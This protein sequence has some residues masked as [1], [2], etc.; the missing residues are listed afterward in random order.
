MP[1]SIIK[2]FAKE[3]G[4]SV[5]EVEKLWNQAKESAKKEGKKESDDSFYAYVTGTLKKML[6]ISEGTTTMNETES[7]SLKMF[8]TFLQEIAAADTLKTTPIG[9]DNKSQSSI[10]GDTKKTM[11][12]IAK[13]ANAATGA[14]DTLKT[15]PTKPED[16]SSAGDDN[17]YSKA[18]L[19]DIEDIP[20]KTK[21]AEYMGKTNEEVLEI[22]VRENIDELIGEAGSMSGEISDQQF[23]KIKAV[24][25]K[26]VKANIGKGMSGDEAIRAVMDDLWNDYPQ[27]AIGF[28]KRFMPMKKEDVSEMSFS[29]LINHIST[30]K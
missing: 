26:H 18:T 14:A 11:A 13:N 19:A 8:G 1:N 16:S 17:P 3:S 10:D 12:D 5:G 30:R 27:V 21:E 22:L 25:G 24:L 28:L 7:K 4:K 6:K 29:E 23:D 20:G 9:T 15:K 2:S